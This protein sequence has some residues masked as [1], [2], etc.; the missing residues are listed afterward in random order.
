M[1]NERSSGP[2]QRALWFVENRLSD[3]LSLNG[4]ADVVGVSPQHLARAFGAATGRSLMNY[5]RGRRLTEGHCH[6]WQEEAPSPRLADL[7]SH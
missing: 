2:V 4:I 1:P 6:I 5:A 3:E 7:L